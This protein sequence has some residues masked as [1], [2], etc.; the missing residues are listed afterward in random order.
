MIASSRYHPYKTC[1]ILELEKIVMIPLWIGD[2][3]HSS[4]SM[5]PNSSFLLSTHCLL[6]L[7]LDQLVDCCRNFEESCDLVPI[8]FILVS[9]FL[10]FDLKMWNDC[11]EL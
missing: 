9:Y 2:F 11:I 3:S 5:L 8:R 10:K 4:H 7:W 6:A 1:V